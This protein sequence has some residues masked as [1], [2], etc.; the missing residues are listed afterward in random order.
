MPEYHFSELHSIHVKAT[1]GLAYSAIKNV[2]PGEIRMFLLLTGIRALNPARVFGRGAEPLG[3]QRPILEVAQG[4][5]FRLLREEPSSEIVL[6]T[7]GQFWRLRGS[8]RCPGIDSP[9]AFLAFSQPGYAKAAINF[10][11]VRENDGCR[12]IT[13]TR[14]L[15]TDP[16]ARRRF[17]AYW[18][19]IYPGSSL[20]RYGW[21]EAIRRRVE[22]SA[23]AGQ[24]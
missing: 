21:L 14:V 13:E 7:C 23:D 10:R 20:I 6:G 19:M 5:G 18:C 1:P 17:A 12:I 24:G 22:S 3:S 2:R 15:A 8:G 9:E 11:V 16:A 4:G